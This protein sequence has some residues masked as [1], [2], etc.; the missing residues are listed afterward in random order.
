MNKKHNPRQERLFI[1]I[2]IAAAFLALLVLG[3]CLVS[4]RL[5]LRRT[6]DALSTA[7]EERRVL[8]E[9]ID[10]NGFIEGENGDKD[11]SAE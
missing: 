4:A 7:R 8:Q 10:I 6:E 1:L 3:G 9:T 2:P 5:R 11:D